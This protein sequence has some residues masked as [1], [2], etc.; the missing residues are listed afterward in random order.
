MCRLRWLAAGGAGACI[1]YAVLAVAIALAASGAAAQSPGGQTSGDLAG[2]GSVNQ[3]RRGNRNGQPRHAALPELPA[4]AEP[5]PR[6]DPGAVLCRT[7]EDFRQYL[8]AVA[9]NLDGATSQIAKPAGCR[10]I[11]RQT[12]VVVV[13]R[14]GPGRTQVRIS[15]PSAETGWTDAY[16]PEKQ[17]NK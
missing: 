12:P 1:L 4:A 17:G 7:A 8:A 6:L 10:L 16:L 14:E 5:W 15:D 11:Q 13:T 2:S 9:A 3:H